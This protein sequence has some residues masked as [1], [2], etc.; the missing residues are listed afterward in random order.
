[1][2][3]IRRRRPRVGGYVPAA[4]RTSRLVGLPA[5][6]R[7]PGGRGTGGI[8]PAV[9]HWRVS[10]A[11]AGPPRSHRRQP[12]PRP[13]PSCVDVA[14]RPS[15]SCAPASL[16]RSRPPIAERCVAPRVA[17]LR[18][19]LDRVSEAPRGDLLAVIGVDGDRGFVGRRT[20]RLATRRIPALRSAV[21]ATLH[22]LG[23]VD[24]HAHSTRLC[25]IEIGLDL[26]V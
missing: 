20:I 18:D 7:R 16:A 26:V 23:Q 15:C 1:M 10:N 4:R 12:G 9:Q 6:C 3:T 5:G 24:G 2:E 8:L 21:S 25:L 19:A 22:L 13:A 17:L 14:T 11:A